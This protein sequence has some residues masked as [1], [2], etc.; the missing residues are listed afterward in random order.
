MNCAGSKFFTSAAMRVVNCS[1][2]SNWVIGPTPLRP[3]IKD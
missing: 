2:A 3:L 1:V